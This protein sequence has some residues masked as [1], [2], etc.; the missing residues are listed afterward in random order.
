MPRSRGAHLPV[1]ASAAVCGVIKGSVSLR[2]HKRTIVD[3][4]AN[5]FERPNDIFAAILEPHVC[6]R[7]VT[8]MGVGDGKDPQLFA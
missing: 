7:A 2:L 4:A 1:G 5:P 3:F 6:R 8:G